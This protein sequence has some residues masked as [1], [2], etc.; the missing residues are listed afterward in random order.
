M[1]LGLVQSMG[2]R[3]LLR[4]LKSRL[5]NVNGERVLIRLWIGKSYRM[6]SFN[7]SVWPKPSKI[8]LSLIRSHPHKYR[9]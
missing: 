3:G 6:I 7:C 9:L 2:N 1:C 8:N 5:R 4:S